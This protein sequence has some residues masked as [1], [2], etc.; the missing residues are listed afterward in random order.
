MLPLFM[1][2]SHSNL[3]IVQHSL[4]ATLYHL[5]TALNAHLQRERPTVL[6][7]SY[8]GGT[9]PSHALDSA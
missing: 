5:R 9:S 3:E 6:N 1:E 4:G 8:D 7:W 2:R